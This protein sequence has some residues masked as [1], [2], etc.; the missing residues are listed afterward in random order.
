MKWFNNFMRGR[1]GVDQLAFGL[2]FVYFLLT[3]LGLFMHNRFITNLALAIMIVCWFRMLSKNIYKRQAENTLYLQKTYPIRTWFNKKKTR[4]ANRKVYK[5][6]KCPNCKQ[7]L[8]VPRGKGKITI[9][10]PK[11]HTKFDKRS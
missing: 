5:Y 9:T 7:E 8:R 2:L 11:C 1:Y 10:C 4:M 6:C 3:F